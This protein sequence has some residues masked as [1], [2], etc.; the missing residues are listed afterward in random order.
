MPG[1][2]LSHTVPV[3]IVI[4]M[5]PLFKMNLHPLQDDICGCATKDCPMMDQCL[6]SLNFRAMQQTAES[7]GFCQPVP[8]AVFEWGEDGCDSFWPVDD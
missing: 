6:R 8:V 2:R 5:Q 3:A 7:E 1:D 4:P